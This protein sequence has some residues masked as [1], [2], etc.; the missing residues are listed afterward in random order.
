ML[1]GKKYSPQNTDDPPYI[2]KELCRAYRE[3]IMAEIRGI[4]TTIVVGLSISTAIISIIVALLQF[5]T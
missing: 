2:S 1:S 4:K 3:S 5:L